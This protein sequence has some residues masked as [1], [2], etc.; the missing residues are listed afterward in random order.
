MTRKTGELKKR[1]WL[2]K[3]RLKMGYFDSI[4]RGQDEDSEPSSVTAVAE[5]A[6]RPRHAEV[7]ASSPGGEKLYRQVC[8]VL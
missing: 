3:Q 6:A 2:A 7:A 4:K 5:F 8:A 1:C